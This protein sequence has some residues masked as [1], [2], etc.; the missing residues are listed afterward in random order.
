MANDADVIVIGAGASGLTAAAAIARHGLSVLVLEARDRIGGRIFTVENFKFKSPV[1]LGAEFIHG[2]PPEIWSLLRHRKI[3]PIEVQGDGWCAQA[4]Q[5][6]RCEF[7]SEVEQILEKMSDRRPDESFL[8]FLERAYPSSNVTPPLAEA[9]KHAIGYV[10]GFNAADPALVGVHWLVKEARAEE[11]IDGGRAFRAPHGYADLL[12]IFQQQLS[13]AAIQIRKNTIVDSIRW[14]PDGAEVT[15]C[16]TNERHI[17]CAPKILVTVPLGVLQSKQEG[18]GRIQFSPQLPQTKL[19]ALHSLAMGK[20]IRV[21]L[22]FRERFWS[23]LPKPIEPEAKD[24]EQTHRTMDNLSFLFS[25]DEWFPTWWTGIDKTLPFLT[26]WAPFRC[27]EKLSGQSEAF[28]VEQALQALHRVFGPGVSELKD[29]FEQAYWHDWQ[30]DP[31]S[32][33]AY[34]YGTVG[35]DGAETALGKPLDGTLFFA[36]EA[37]DTTGNNGTVH[38]AI[39]SGKRAA[40]E[41]IGSMPANKSRAGRIRTKAKKSAA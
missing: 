33:G 14:S 29:L 17:F 25:D 7:F 21:T 22:Q 15:A 2:R 28:V 12:A 36:G 16:A 24:K 23:A 34:S 30:S 3:K 32:Q 1:E 8:D 13:G 9:K 35:G 4:N 27:A 40:A 5:L 38:G 20:I 10:S 41:I 31:F 37:T 11:T 26:G 18:N 6:T 19:D 39:A